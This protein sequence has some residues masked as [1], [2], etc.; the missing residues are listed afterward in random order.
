[1]NAAM[2]VFAIPVFF[3][4]VGIELLI[5]RW[6]RRKVY[7]LADTLANVG[8]GLAMQIVGTFS[9]P[10]TFG[11]Y[12]WVWKH[13]RLT[14]VSKSSLVAWLALFVAI[15]FCYYV[16]HRISHRVNFF[17]ATHVVHHQ[18]EEFNYSV[19][20]RQTWFAQ[21]YSW[22][23]Y[24]PL[25]L[26][27]FPPLM[28]AITNTVN[29][30]YQFLLHTRLV[31]RLGPLEWV[32]NT[33]SH[34]RVHHGVNPRYVDRNYGGSLIIWDRLFGT[35]EPE[36]DEPIYGLVKPI[37]SFDPLWANLQY[38]VE[39]ATMA[40]RTRRLRDKL[41]ALVAPP[42]WRPDDLGGPIV[43]PEPERTGPTLVPTSNRL[44][45]LVVAPAFAATIAG[46][47]LFL[48]LAATYGRNHPA[49]IASAIAIV[50]LVILFART[51]SP[52]TSPSAPDPIS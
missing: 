12:I 7:R 47:A 29:M 21:L 32:L 39:I 48:H 6:R 34:H 23:F 10:V 30:F 51:Y 40:R 26:V 45:D 44:R 37:D 36:G 15:D 38:W 19:G 52:A 5:A 3:T 8:N 50:A 31:G 14:T 9:I 49:V 4:I 41:R 20:L 16:Y 18:S 35:F 24:L 11:I 2:V 22:I 46:T 17:W 43:I 13:A 25:A 28:F 1:M 42:E 27:G 33:P